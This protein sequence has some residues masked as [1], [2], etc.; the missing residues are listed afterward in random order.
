MSLVR[1]LLLF[2]VAS[3]GVT[4]QRIDLPPGSKPF[5]ISFGS[6]DGR[7]VNLDVHSGDYVEECGRNVVATLYGE[8]ASRPDVEQLVTA[9]IRERL[10]VFRT[11]DH[12]R[13][14][15]YVHERPVFS[16]GLDDGT[17]LPFY[18]GDS[19]QFGEYRASN[20]VSV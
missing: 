8:T 2:L 7:K 14:N 17:S 10:K 11:E 5:R 9:E 18:E 1:H 13:H 16:L 6:E 15:P 20:V 3:R 12:R 19:V 4:P